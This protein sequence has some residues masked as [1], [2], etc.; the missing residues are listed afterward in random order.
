MTKTSLVIEKL[1]HLVRSG[2]WQESLPPVTSLSEQ[3][4]VSPGTVSLAIRSLEKEGLVR[5]VP[6]QGVFI[7][8]QSA[9]TTPVSLVPTIGVRGSYVSKAREKSSVY[10]YSLL[11]SLLEA[12]NHKHGALLMLPSAPDSPAIDRVACE[13]QGIRGMI[14]L[15][16][17]SEAEAISLREQGFP[18]ICGNK[19]TAT[20]ALNYVDYDHASALR[21]IIHRFVE[22]GHRRIA[23]LFPKVTSPRR[24]E[25]LQPDFINS[26]CEADIYYNPKPYWRHVRA[27]KNDMS[28]ET[29]VEQA[30]RDLML[31]AEPPTAIYCH[32]PVIADQVAPV[33]E[34]LGLS[35]PDDVSL[36]S[37]PHNNADEAVYSGFISPH[38]KHAQQILESLYA[39]IAQPFHIAQIGIPLEFLDKGS[40]RAP[41][42]L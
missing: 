20:Q 37:S 16:G 6:R 12:A 24:Y 31:L 1:G 36:A 2:E 23:V 19:P 15:G 9:N 38:D 25:S 7:I 14:F 17:E 22:V 35:I 4:G 41:R 5:V 26:L 32:S 27:H 21:E 33:L 30:V 8:E 28:S 40:I 34:S 13:R 39:T 3:F 42:R 29:S 11:S 10:A 18:V